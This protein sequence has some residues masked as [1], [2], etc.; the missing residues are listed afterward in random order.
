MNRVIF[1]TASLALI[2]ACEP[3]ENEAAIDLAQYTLDLTVEGE[4]SVVSLPEAIVCGGDAALC[5]AEFAQDTHVTLQARALPGH[6]FL[7]WQGNCAGI[8]TEVVDLVMDGH[9]SCLAQFIPQEEVVEETTHQL[10]VVVLGPGTVEAIAG[11]E[12]ATDANGEEAPPF[13]CGDETCV[14]HVAAGTIVTLEARAA[15]N[16]ALVGF[17]GD[18]VEILSGT[19]EVTMDADRTCT[20][21]FFSE[22]DVTYPL[23]VHVS[24]NGHVSS[25]PS[26]VNCTESSAL[27]SGECEGRFAYG[28]EITLQADAEGNSTFVGWTHA[29]ETVV[30]PVALVT[31]YYGTACGAV[32]ETTLD[33]VVVGGGTVTG[34]GVNCSGNC[35]V[36]IEGPLELTATADAGFRFTGWSEDCAAGVADVTVATVTADASNARCVASFERIPPTLTV[37]IDGAGS[38]DVTG[39]DGAIA[40]ATGNSGTCAT[41]VLYEPEIIAAHQ[42]GQWT[43]SF[44]LYGTGLG[45]NCGCGKPDPDCSSSSVDACQFFGDC[46]EP[47]I[48]PDRNHQCTVIEGGGTATV[49]L[50]ATPDAGFAFAGW[51][52]ACGVVDPTANPVTVEVPDSIACNA[53]FV[54]A[55]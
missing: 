49:T 9:V 43:C 39:V 47:F 51:T 10:T 41:E 4:G 14:R 36:A 15:P 31:V 13:L 27:D 25:S 44:F 40:C 28:T 19:A 38:G 12:A 16:A 48:N 5:H 30:G 18:C 55:P 52:G 26:G 2:S 17:S 29:C 6:A 20:V 45:C 32:F 23:R 22:D 3:V 21:S 50:T 46:E 37:T 54:P 11:L 34:D 8:A 42:S 53:T 33:V 24:G 1:F 7:Q 35:D